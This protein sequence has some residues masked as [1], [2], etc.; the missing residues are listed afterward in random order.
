MVHVTG[1]NME[2]VGVVKQMDRA[3]PLHGE[4]ENNHDPKILESAA[5]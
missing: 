1:R 3:D 5:N 4:S 2:G